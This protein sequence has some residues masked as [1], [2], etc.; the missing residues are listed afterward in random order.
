MDTVLAVD[1]SGNIC[2]FVDFAATCLSAVENPSNTGKRNTIATLLECA[3]KVT[4]EHPEEEALL[5]QEDEILIRLA[6]QCQAVSSHLLIKLER[7]GATINPDRQPVLSSEEIQRGIDQIRK[8]LDEKLAPIQWVSVNRM[9]RELGAKNSR[10]DAN[11][12]T[13]IEVLAKSSDASFESIKSKDFEESEKSGH[14]AQIV[15]GLQKVMDYTAEQVVLGALQ[16][17]TLDRRKE[18]IS[19]EHKNTFEWILEESHVKDPSESDVKFVD[20][21]KSGDPLYWI[22]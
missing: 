6:N 22:S 9:I 19:K 2:Q 18:F 17:W 10:L 3:K 15:S 7:A 14:W 13:E 1:L 12:T 4:F 21:L 20:W 8:N 5:P 16:F 11:R